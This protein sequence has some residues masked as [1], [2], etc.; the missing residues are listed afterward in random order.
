MI[1]LRRY[2]L[3]PAAVITV[4]LALFGLVAALQPAVL[5]DPDIGSRDAGV[6]AATLG[7][8]L[9]VV[10]ALLPVPSS[11]VMVALGATFGAP[12]GA[13]LSLLGSLGG[14]LVGFAAGRGGRGRLTRFVP[15]DELRRADALLDRWGLLAIVVT[16]PVP[17]LAETTAAMA[18]ASTMRFAPATLAAVAGALPGAVIYALAGSLAADASMEIVVLV[19]VLAVGGALWALGRRR[20]R[21]LSRSTT[22]GVVGRDKNEQAGVRPP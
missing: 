12:L 6:A 4:T 16:R 2:W 13:A 8:G 17:I 5:T 7:V 15:E 21:F 11:V 10:D 22:S 19:T 9:L 3:L 14:F 18:G 20:P 1:R